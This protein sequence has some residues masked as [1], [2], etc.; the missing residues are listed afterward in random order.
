MPGPVDNDPQSAAT[1][2]AELQARNARVL[3]V[4]LA[5]VREMGTDDYSRVADY[6]TE[7]PGVEP[8]S[9]LHEGLIAAGRRI[10][11]TRH[12]LIENEEGEEGEGF[13][14]RTEEIRG[15]FDMYWKGMRQALEVVTGAVDDP[16]QF[17]ARDAL[18]PRGIQSITN[19]GTEIASDPSMVPDA[20][21]D[22]LE[23]SIDHPLEYAGGELAQANARILVHTIGE[24]VE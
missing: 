11:N 1:E 9:D 22:G 18:F 12:V 20:V 16:E 14:E 4:T 17:V 10:F 8:D 7:Y 21:M 5:F 19:L 15:G 6:R 13:T 23:Y 3:A 24:H 2:A